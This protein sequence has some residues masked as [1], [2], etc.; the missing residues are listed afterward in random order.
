GSIVVTF[1]DTGKGIA[2]AD[3]PQI[4][5]PFFTTKHRGSGLGLPI[6]VKIVEAHGGALR[7]T[8]EAGEGTTATVTLPGASTP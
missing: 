7:V 1:P 5:Q 3:L 8:S 4:F 6:V 2:P